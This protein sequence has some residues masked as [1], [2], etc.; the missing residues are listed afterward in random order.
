MLLQ[1]EMP[2]LALMD[3]KLILFGSLL[4]SER[5][6]LCAYHRRVRETPFSAFGGARA[7]LV[8][9]GNGVFILMKR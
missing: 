4:A 1:F 9:R 5:A 7:G 3:R 8:A 6:W 2:N